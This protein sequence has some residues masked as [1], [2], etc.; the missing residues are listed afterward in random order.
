MN[1]LLDTLFGPLNKNSCIY[2]LLLTVIF[3]TVLVFALIIEIIYIIRNIKN[4]NVRTFINLILILFNLFIGYFVNR[5]LYTMCS[6]S[7]I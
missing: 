2:F 7:L 1:D 4:L 6:N 3:F 5:I